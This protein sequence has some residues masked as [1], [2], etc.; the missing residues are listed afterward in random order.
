MRPDGGMRIRGWKTIAAFSAAF[1]ALLTLSG[2]A[3]AQAAVTS[4]VQRDALQQQERILRDQEER[5]RLLEGQHEER[6]RRPPSVEPAAPLA[7]SAFPD[8]TTCFTAQAIDLDGIAAADRADFEDVLAPYVGRCLTLKDV[9][10]IVRAVTNLYVELGYVTTRVYIPSQDV[11][12]GTL[13]LVIIEGVLERLNMDGV[14]PDDRRLTTAFPGLEGEV[15]NLRD[16]EQGLDQMNRLRSNNVTMSLEPG[17]NPGGSVVALTNEAGRRVYASF[18]ID[19]AGSEAVGEAQAVA[20]VE[21]ND[22]LR[23][24]DLWTIEGRTSLARDRDRRTSNSFSALVSVPYGAW[25]A[26]ANGSWFDY[27]SPITSLRQTFQTSGASRQI[28][29]RL[30][31]LLH[32][33]G[34]GKTSLAVGL[35]VKDSVSY[36]E[37]LRLDTGS[38]RLTVLTSDLR[39]DRRV[40]DGVASASIGYARGLRLLNPEK[41]REDDGAKPRAQFEKWVAD[42]NYRRPLPVPPLDLSWQVAGRAQWTRDTLYSAERI[43]VGGLSSVRGFKEE[44]LGGDNGAYLRNDLILTLPATG[45]AGFDEVFGRIRATA[46][47]DIGASAVTASEPYAAGWLEGVALAL[48]ATGGVVSFD[49]TW[50]RPL[51]APSFIRRDE[52]AVYVSVGL[53]Y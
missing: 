18:D 19:N 14:G 48:S 7:P 47:Y 4:E 25:T 12:S 27:R 26:T 39:H 53:A 38:R 29:G 1:L 50:A 20:Q 28:G 51:R 41:D 21:F 42:A 22:I 46:A 37:D 49:V 33:D 5:R 34:V 2:P 52:D 32:R 6:L 31:R 23:V 10:D 24:N 17:E 36:I 35:G 44:T 3:Q 13:R 9:D 8:G 45:W 11:A 30:E 40:G 16:L 15:L 43:G